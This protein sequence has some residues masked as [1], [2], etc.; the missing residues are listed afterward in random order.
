MLGDFLD[1]QLEY[2]LESEWYLLYRAE[3]YLNTSSTR[4]SFG[5]T[6]IGNI[7]EKIG[8]RAQSEERI[9]IRLK[10]RERCEGACKK[11]GR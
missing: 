3:Y 2:R 6:G 10:R 7:S 9:K 1:R 8:G 5:N 4:A 11:D